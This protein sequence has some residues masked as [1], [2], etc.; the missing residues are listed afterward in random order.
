VD[1]PTSALVRPATE[2]ARLTTSTQGSVATNAFRVVAEADAGARLA[3][4]RRHGD[5]QRAPALAQATLDREGGAPLMVAVDGR[6]L[7]VRLVDFCLCRSR[8][9]VH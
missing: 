1:A 8:S 2:V 9:P 6:H 5:E 3:G 4:P 7:R